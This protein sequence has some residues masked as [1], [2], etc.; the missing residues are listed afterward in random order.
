[1]Y[2]QAD[3]RWDFFFVYLFGPKYDMFGPKRGIIGTEYKKGKDDKISN[4]FCRRRC[5]EKPLSSRSAAC[6]S[7]VLIM[8]DDKWY[9]KCEK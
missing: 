7:L 1:M 9:M 8:C 2:M 5:L 4:L 6:G 3:N